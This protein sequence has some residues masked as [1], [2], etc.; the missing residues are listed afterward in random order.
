MKKSESINE[1]ISRF[2]ISAQ[3]KLKQ[4]RAIIK[5]NVP[6]AEE[7]ISYGMPAYKLNGPL[8]YFAAYKNHIGF[9][10]TPVPILAFK[11]ELKNYKTSKGAVQ[12]PLDEN[13]PVALIG[14]MLRFKVKANLS[15]I[16][17]KK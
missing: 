13:L 9:Y 1:Y 3:K 10:P 17:S 16:R 14:K 15:K 5:K 12:F 2:P 8:V 7:T 6:K 11:Q 4:L